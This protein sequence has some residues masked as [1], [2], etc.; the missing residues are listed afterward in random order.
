MKFKDIT[1]GQTHGGT[2]F[3]F[4]KDDKIEFY[5]PTYLVLKD[6]CPSIVKIQNGSISS[7]SY[8]DDIMNEEIKIIYL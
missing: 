3:K 7:F 5:S 4:I 2:K 1:S 8:E 6:N